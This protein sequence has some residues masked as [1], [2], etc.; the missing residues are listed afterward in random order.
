MNGKSLH[1]EE[2]SAPR[3]LFR[4]EGGTRVPGSRASPV[5]VSSLC[6]SFPR[7]LSKS[8][9]SLRLFFQSIV[10]EPY[11][12]SSCT[13]KL[14]EAEVF[15]RDVWPIPIPFP[16][17]FRRGGFGKE[18]WKKR[19][20]AMEILILDW[21]HLGSP[22]AAPPSLRIGSRLSRK[23]WD[24]VRYLL[25]VS[26][27][28]NTP[29]LVDVGLMGRAA[30]K[31]ENIE[32]ALFFISDS[33]STLHQSFGGYE[34]SRGERPHT[35]DDEWLR[36]GSLKHSIPGH[37]V[38]VAKPIVADRLKFP[39]APAFDP[40]QYFDSITAEL[41]LH[42]IDHAQDWREGGEQP[43]PV[44]VNATVGEKLLLFRK[45][46]DCGRLKI[47]D[48]EYDRYPYVS[49]LFAVGKSEVKDR[50]ILD[51]RPPNLLEAPRTVWCASM[52]SSSCLTDLV[53]EPQRIMVCSGLDLTD[54]FYQFVISGQR[55]VRNRLAGSLTLDQARFVFND[56]KIHDDSGHI[57]VAL[58]TLAMGDLLA[59][60]FAQ[61]AHLG[62]C[63]QHGVC[64]PG[65]LLSFRTP[66]PRSL[67]MTGIVI[68]DLV[69]LQQIL[70]SE[71]H[72]PPGSLD[73]ELR[74][75]KALDGYKQS[76]LL[77][78]PEKGFTREVC[79]RFWGSEI[80]GMKGLVRGS[81]L[82]MW[83]LLCLT[84]RIALLGF[85]TVKLMEILS[86]CW[87]ALLTT[88]RRLL[89][90][91]N[92]IFE[93]LG[94]PDPTQVIKLSPELIDELFCICGL[95][96]LAVADL[97][98]Q[99][100]PFVTAT[101]ASSE[102]MAAVRAPLDSKLV[103]EAARYSLK[104]GN[105]SRLLP[106]DK[107][108]LKAQG[109]LDPTEEMPE[110]SYNTHPLWTTLASSLVYEERWRSPCKVGQHIN[111]LELKAFLKEEKALSRSFIG[112]RFLAGLDSQVSLG[113]LVKG[114]AAAVS[115]NSMLRSSLCY[116]LGSGLFGYYMYYASETNRADGPTRHK[117]PDPPN[118]PRPIWMQDI[119]ERNDFAAFDCWMDSV[120]DG[121]VSKPF[122]CSLLMNG[123]ELDCRPRQRVRR[124]DRC[125][126]D[127]PVPST[128]PGI[129]VAD[130]LEDQVSKDKVEAF[131]DGS[132]DAAEGEGGGELSPEALAM[133]ETIPEEQFFFGVPKDKAFLHR[134]ALDL[135]SGSYGIA[136]Q[137]IANGAPWV[138]TY[139]W[140]RSAK[141]NLLDPVLQ[142]FILQMVSLGCFLAISMAPICASFSMAVTP[143]VRTSRYPRGRPGLSAAMR[144]KVKQG[145][146][147][148]EFTMKIVAAAYEMDIGFFLE[149]P[150]GSWFWRQKL[151]VRFR[152]PA[153]L[154]LFR[155]SFCR[156]GTAW[157][158]NTRVATSTRLRGL[159]MMCQCHGRHHQLRGYSRTHKKSW[160]AVAEP[161]PR[162][163]CR[164][165]SIALC[166]KAGWCDQ[167]KLNV[168]GCAKLKN[169]R[170]GEAQNPGPRR[171]KSQ[172]LPPRP[173]LEELPGILPA[174]L[175]MESKL[176]REFLRWCEASIQSTSPAEIFD[177]V[178]AFLGTTLR[179]YGDLCFQSHGSLANFRHLILACQRWKPSCRPFTS[180]AWELVKRWEIQV[181]VTHRPPTP[182]AVVNAQPRGIM[183]GMN[184]LALP[185]SLSM[186]LAGWVRR[187]VAED[188][189]SL[190][191]LILVKKV[192]RVSSCSCGLSNLCFA[193][194]EEYNI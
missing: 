126:V 99:F 132:N 159:R 108:W 182:E 136:K 62:L 9:G 163:L 18:L 14:A 91:M 120:E 86:G 29:E 144:V 111:I 54:Y 28:G 27:D 39:T 134:G 85:S 154:D 100:L 170:P 151:T 87:V 121:V 131:R 106:P 98:A 135:Y 181:P 114:R 8:G 109:L 58:G 47:V 30:M 128:Q 183:V 124:S 22:C 188:R 152:S 11:K 175:Q 4:D 53:I 5:K 41:Y 24:V 143:A 167:R 194:L 31:F 7:W 174:T 150:D 49:G 66:V 80:D 96:P 23:Q 92:I 60:E 180:T 15:N 189:T 75:G 122:D 190:C 51:A 50:L 155:F 165:L 147:H 74:I 61:A 173:T 97:R 73:S 153:S 101:D 38:T 172:S 89:C 130:E 90:V 149:N 140:K 145:N 156:F 93:P 71:L 35:F 46:A 19:V 79:S 123:V 157:Q 115:L 36:C 178:P 25:H 2:R 94:L 162:G 65:S 21:L 104:K 40:L 179:S 64:D 43:P 186:A 137:M 158:K 84:C 116:P 161:Y 16:E 32:R 141:E 81:S 78:N 45:L 6:N 82:R 129:G 193:N 1:V 76:N 169:L 113:S 146:L 33:L 139:E 107:A 160:T 34:G 177:R 52:A 110:E 88:R 103:Q 59:C 72:A 125:R 148:L 168:A 68:D 118:L 56:P 119:V 176:L 63:L 187:F 17:V 70:E 44:K 112:K 55:T 77:H 42:P 83:P 192:S 3:N 133:L 184:G 67:S 48:K 37:D 166:C 142:N 102:W 57:L 26:F 191:R 12:S 185:S 13:S 138:L 105:W 117:K 171:R 10:N 164:L 69:A 20:V 127:R 95:A